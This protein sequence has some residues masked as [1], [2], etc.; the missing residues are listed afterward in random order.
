V[1]LGGR[2][3]AKR[4]FLEMDMDTHTS[5]DRFKRKLA[6]YTEFFA[7]GAYVARFGNVPNVVVLYV[8][9]FGEKRREE[10]R[11]WTQEHF[12]QPLYSPSSYLSGTQTPDPDDFDTFLFAA[13]PP[14]SLDPLTTLLSPI[15]YSV[16][17]TRP[18]PLIRLPKQNI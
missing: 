15:C 7:S 4:V 5:R 2:L 11:K 13:V 10:M 9:P 1:N 6:A 17:D 14:G 16:A 8:T 3:A 18:Q 12:T